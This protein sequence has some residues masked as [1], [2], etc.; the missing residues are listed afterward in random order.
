MTFLEADALKRVSGVAQIDAQAQ[1]TVSYK[2]R[3]S[4]L[5]IIGTEPGAFPESIGTVI[6]SGRALG[7]SDT[8]SCVIGYSVMAET[9]NDSMLNKQIKINGAA[10]RV[11]GV[12]NKS[13]SSFSG[14]DRNIYISQKAAKKTL[15]PDRIRKFRYCG[16]GKRAG[17]G[18]S[19]TK[20]CVRASHDAPRQRG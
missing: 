15:Q 14:P 11:I 7:T 8:S 13:G 18:Y 4:S 3:N 16:G 12:L 1:G 10:F 20:P 6:S 9:F 5:T 2:N 19:C 17:F